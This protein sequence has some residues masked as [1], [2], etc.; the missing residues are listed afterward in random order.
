MCSKKSEPGRQQVTRATRPLN[1]S[2]NGEL[3]PQET[4]GP[5]ISSACRLLRAVAAV[6]MI[7]QAATRA[8]SL[9]L[10]AEFRFDGETFNWSE[11]WP[12]LGLAEE[13]I[14]SVPDRLWNPNRAAAFAMGSNVGAAAGSQPSRDLGGAI[15][16]LR[17][18][19][20]VRTRAYIAAP[21]LLKSTVQGAY[22]ARY[23]GTH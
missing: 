13:Q 22:V 20:R 11:P 10:L 15:D 8:R 9:G 1:N 4:K 14:N 21:T 6:P 16:A 18:L 2:T 3:P 5:G 19:N 7:D 23:V 17:S 12:G